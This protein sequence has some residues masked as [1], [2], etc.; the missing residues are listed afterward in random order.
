MAQ[1]FAETA[2]L[3]TDK[4]KL[5][6]NW[7]RINWGKAERKSATYVVI[8][9]EVVECPFALPGK[10]VTDGMCGESG[11]KSASE[12]YRQWKEDQRVRI[13]NERLKK[14]EKNED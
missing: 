1:S 9:G 11:I 13:I 2:H 6:E 12:E 5:D 14:E 7:D 10:H 8:E 4:K 3:N